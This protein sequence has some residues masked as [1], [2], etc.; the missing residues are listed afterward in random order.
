MRPQDKAAALSALFAVRPLAALQSGQPCFQCS[1]SV[2]LFARCLIGSTDSAGDEDIDTS[3]RIH[4]K[5]YD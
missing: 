5:G 1:G 4:E 3:V 2:K